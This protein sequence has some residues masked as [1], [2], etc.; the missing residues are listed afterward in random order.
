MRILLTGGAGFIGSHLAEKYLQ[1]G[2]EVFVLDN[3]STAVPTNLAHLEKNSKLH[4]VRESIL[5]Y[6]VALELVGTC[7]A[8]FH[9]AAAVGVRLIIEKPLETLETNTQGTEI[10][11]RLCNKFRKKVMIFSTSE[12]YGK[13]ENVPLKEDYDSITGATTI[14]RWSYSCSKAYDEF[15]ALAYHRTKGLPVVIVRLFNT[16]G[17]RQTGEY[18]MVIPRLVQQALEGKDLTVHGDGQ[19]T[20]T[21]GFVK[22][23]IKALAALMESP[24]ALGEV[25]NI[26]GTEEVSILDLAQR[27]VKLSG[28]KSHVKLVPYDVAYEK[29]FEDMRRRVPDCSKL[30][31]TI[32]FRPETP[33]NDILKEVIAYYRSARV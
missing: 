6:D 13:N 22:D 3:Y 9:L 26:G 2:H 19:Q 14:S 7:D 30:K 16:V 24:K 32:G 28:S 17:P 33:L 1:E 10:I 25:F 20:R 23:V 21:F 15:L 4:I 27:V 11:L 12:I 29:G 8:V 5:N 18:G 31:A